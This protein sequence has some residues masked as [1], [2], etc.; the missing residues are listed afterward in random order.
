MHLPVTEPRS[1]LTSDSS[2][3]F[4]RLF[5]AIAVPPELQN[6]IG[7]AQGRLRRSSPPGAIRWT[8]PEQFHVTLMFLGDV[9]TAQV[10]ALEESAAKVCAGC[11]VLKLSAQGIGFFPSPQRAR[12]IWAGVDDD[13]GQL[14]KLQ[15]QLEEAIR[16]FTPAERWGKFTSHITL[17]RFKPGYHSAT[18]NLLKHATSLYQFHFGD[19]QARE[20]E[21]VRSELTSA[22]ARHV[23][24]ASFLLAE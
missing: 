23:S 4:L 10:A 6:E 2:A 13:S 21:I 12:V 1:T 22:G 16:P 11:K 24:L 5:V 3:G 14:S 20:V 9:R 17:G 7:L 18:P 15:R 8:P 19:W